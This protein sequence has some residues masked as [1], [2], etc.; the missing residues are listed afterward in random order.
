MTALQAQPTLPGLPAGLLAPL[1]GVSKRPRRGDVVGRRGSFLGRRAHSVVGDAVENP[2]AERVER[3]KL[4]RRQAFELLSLIQSISTRR[5]TLACC[6]NRIKGGGDVE[7]RIKGGVAYFAGLQRCASVWICP[8]C[9]SKISAVRRAEVERVGALHVERGGSIG[10]LTLTTSHDRGMDPR[11]LRKVVAESWRQVQQDKRYREAKDRLGYVGFLRAFE[12]THG[13]NGFHPHIH[14]AMFFDRDFAPITT[15]TTT[16]LREREEWIEVDD[17]GHCETV[18]DPAITETTKVVDLNPELVAFADLIFAIWRDAIV[19]HG[20]PPP[21]REHGVKLQIMRPGSRA[22][23]RY[24][25]KVGYE[26]A[27]PHHKQGRN[28]SRSMW[29]VAQDAG[30]EQVRREALGLPTDVMID[31]TTTLYLP[32][33]KAVE[34]PTREFVTVDGEVVDRVWKGQI[35]SEIADV[36]IW[37]EF[38]RMIFGAR[39]IEWSR[40]MK[41]RYQVD[42]QTDLEIIDAPVG[43]DL[44]VAFPKQTWTAIKRRG[45]GALAALIEAGSEGPVQLWLELHSWGDDVAVADLRWGPLYDCGDPHLRVGPG[46][47]GGG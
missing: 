6:R 36:T 38:E 26:F 17:Q 3:A 14:L 8:V 45:T 13:K 31:T 4:L 24:L 39:Q 33:G 25:T 27:A 12:V 20:Y 21:D 2:E 28:G 18:V 29:Q 40:G 15:T 23:A 35:K 1:E 22:W 42:T 43:G 44:M 46:G 11:K 7:L 32:N 9:A 16:V 34:V 41:A 19:G 37:R 47:G 5:R 30:A 10:S